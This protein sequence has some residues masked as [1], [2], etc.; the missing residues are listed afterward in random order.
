[1]TYQQLYDIALNSIK[2]TCLNI[3]NYNAIPAEFKSGYSTK[4][5]TNRA[6]LTITIV[7]PIGQVAST[8][9]DSEFSAWIAQ[10]GINLSA[11]IDPRGLLNF[12]VALASFC[13]AKVRVLGGQ[14]SNTKQMV[15]IPDGAPV[16]Y[17][18]I[19]TGDLLVA[20]DISTCTGTI[21]S[22]IS[23]NTKSYPIQYTFV[24]SNT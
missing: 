5:T 11:Q 7:N 10:C 15:Y 9:A 16:I 23:N 18:T 3:S 22:I 14:Q 24:M 13:S 8:T 21:N 17:T 6:V 1:M 20:S 12:Y 19:P 2:S 4:Q